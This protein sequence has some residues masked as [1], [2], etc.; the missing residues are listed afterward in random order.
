MKRYWKIAVAPVPD[1]GMIDL[2]TEIL[3]GLDGLL[4]RFVF[5]RTCILS[6][7]MP[8]AILI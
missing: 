7:R 5:Y 3:H 4:Y 1:E 8:L 6:W 2:M